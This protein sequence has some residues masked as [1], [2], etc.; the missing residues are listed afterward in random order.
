MKILSVE[1]GFSMRPDGQT[2]MKNLLVA[3]G[4][5][6][7][8]TKNS[9]RYRNKTEGGNKTTKEYESLFFT[10][11]GARVQISTLS[12]IQARN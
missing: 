2:D 5:F 9:R 11:Y 8:A 1:A 6:A 4:N 10:F 12:P 7:K 3:F